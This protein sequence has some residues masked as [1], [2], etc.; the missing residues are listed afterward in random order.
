MLVAKGVAFKVAH[1]TV[2]KLV[3]YAL[4]KNKQIKDMGEKELKLFSPYFTKVEVLKR[5]DP[6]SSAAHKKSIVR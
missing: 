5:F 2:G 3:N 4:S 6:D 1:E